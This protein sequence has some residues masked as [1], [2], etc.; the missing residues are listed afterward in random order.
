MYDKSEKENLSE[1]KSTEYRFGPLRER[2]ALLTCA[3]R[4][5][6]VVL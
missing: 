2:S 6:D 3:T 5:P 4:D 1:F